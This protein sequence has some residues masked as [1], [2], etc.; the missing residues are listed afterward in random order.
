MVK[1][2][3]QARLQ[4]Q[5][6][7]RADDQKALFSLI[8]NMSGK[9]KRN[10][11]PEI[12]GNDMDLAN[13]FNT[14]FVNKINNIRLDF[15]D[16]DVNNITDVLST[17]NDEN[18]STCLYNFRPCSIQEISDIIKANGITVSPADPLPASLLDDN[19]DILLPLI[20]DLVNLSLSKGNMDGLLKEAIIRPLLKDHDIDINKLGN[21]RPVSNLQFLGKLIERVVLSRLQ[22]HMD[23]INYHNN[24]Q[25]GYK[26]S[27]STEL[28][29]LK[30]INDILVGID[31]KNGVVVLL[32]DLSAAFDTVDNKKL[33]NILCN[34]LKIRGNALKWF[35]SF[36]TNRSQ[37]VLIGSC[38]SESVELSCG[39]PQGSVLGPILFNIYTNSL[40][41]VFNANGF[42]TLSYA[43]DNSGYQIFSLSSSSYT[44]NEAIP[45]CI[46]QIKTWMNEFFLKINEDK[47]KIIVFGRPAFH[48]EFNHTEVTLNSGE[49][50]TITD[51]I[52]YL[53]F[54]FDKLLSLTT[55]VNKVVSHCYS[56]LKTVRKIRRFLTQ[57][58]VKLVVH[59]VISSR[60]DYCNCLLFGAQKVNCINK[61][62]RVQ[63]TA[64][65]IVLQ[66]GRHQGYPSSLRLEMLHWLPIEKRIIY[67]CLVIIYN[68]FNGT[69]PV[70][71]SSMLVRKF[72]DSCITDDDFNPDFD[73][74]L[75]YPTFDIGRRAFQFYAPR[76]WNVLP[77]DLCSC[78][79]KNKFKK[80][81]K[82]YLWDSF[83]EL[84]CNFNRF[85]NM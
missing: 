62:Q 61:L 68:C 85:R 50:V 37:C 25:F 32:I 81:L 63:N 47:T 26:K 28:L 80:Q 34:E 10:V 83:D 75:F 42:N 21:Y 33:L 72:P 13:N 4:C 20:T 41:N 54:H 82:T 22:E 55:H 51:R 15:S 1:S 79:N 64:S 60:L 31:S 23:T 76:L 57:A 36:L 5:I 2:K 78:T 48:N 53:G 73:E 69:A 40:S 19:I 18:D 44:F 12:Y 43:D 71:L 38:L 52:K 67:K 7:S 3:K 59:S 58:Q 74:R 6:I 27:H 24:T 49:V 46:S 66:K 70:L 65:K 8:N 16:S 77:I 14:F 17:A 29:L 30:F 84:M 56:L 9:P 45:N 11:Y 39:V 35:K